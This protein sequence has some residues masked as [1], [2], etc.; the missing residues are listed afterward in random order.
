MEDD[1]PAFDGVRTLIHTFSH[2]LIRR[3][4]LYTGIDE[5]SCSEILFP[6]SAA[7]LLYSTSNINIGGFKYVFE[8]SLSNWFEDIKLDI[9]DCVFDPSCLND[10]GACFSCLYL[11]EYVC[12]EFNGQLDRD[13][14]SAKTERWKKGFWSEF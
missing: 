11:P 7:F 5:D 8:N 12:S 10:G 9:D 13:V 1:S 14:F 6:K 4:S 2:I 3:S